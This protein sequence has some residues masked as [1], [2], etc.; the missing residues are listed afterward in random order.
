LSTIKNQP[1]NRSNPGNFIV[2][3]GTLES[4]PDGNEL[5]L[6]WCTEPLPTDFI[7]KLEWLRWGDRDNS[8]VFIRFPK[9]DSKGYDNTAYVGVNFGFEV[10]IDE[11]AQPN[12]DPKSKTG[13]I[14]SFAS[15]QNRSSILPAGQ[16]QEFEIRVQGQNYTVLLNS[17]QVTTFT[18]NGDPTF[19]ERGLVEPR[20]VGLQSYPGA[21]VAFRKIQFKAV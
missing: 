5:G 4:V 9:P 11:Y 3:D 19:P 13:A 2:V 20:F 12:G 16:W 15:P 14:Y 6:Y 10:Q 21:R 1:P 7:L 8:G 18:F 17:V